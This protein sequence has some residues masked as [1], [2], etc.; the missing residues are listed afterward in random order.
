MSVP[1]SDV[2]WGQMC[3]KVRC[4]SHCKVSLCH[5]L[6]DKCAK[7]RCVYVKV[8]CVCHF[9]M[10]MCQ[11]SIDGCAEVRY[12]CVKDI[13]VYHCKMSYFKV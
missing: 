8:V 1:R 6:I 9:K 5:V 3:V 12:V 13:F 2:C 4:V 11:G 7:V 10:Y